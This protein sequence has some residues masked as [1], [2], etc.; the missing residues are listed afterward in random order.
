MSDPKPATPRT[1]APGV[2]ILTKPRATA[3][4]TPAGASAAEPTEAKKVAKADTGKTTEK[5]VAKVAAPAS[6]KVEAKPAPKK[7]TATAK[8]SAATTTTTSA[9]P[10][11][12]PKAAKKASVDPA[13]LDRMIAEEAYYI[14]ER[15][16]FA[17]GSEE[18]DWLAAKEA[19][20]QRLGQTAS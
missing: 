16:N 13:E 14:A 11:A 5:K 7:P 1:A 15:R 3:T 6:T 4:K 12:A 8:K 10:K 17:P 20:L 9:K 19:V 2:S 18:E